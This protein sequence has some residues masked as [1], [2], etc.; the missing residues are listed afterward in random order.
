VRVALALALVFACKGKD[1]EQPTP[2]PSGSA[3]ATDAAPAV[4]W[5]IACE[6][7]LRGAAKLPPVRRVQ[8]VIDGCQPCGEWKPLLLWNTMPPDG[9]TRDQIEQSMLACKGFCDANGKQRFLNNLDD[10]RGKP[11][12]L[13]WRLLGEI[14]K[15]AVSAEPD[16]RY[17]T[18]PLFA[19]DRIGRAAAD[20]PKLAALLDTLELPLPPVSRSGAGYDL[21]PS[22]ATTPNAGPAQITVTLDEIRVGALARAKLG[23]SG[24]QLVQPGESYPGA[25]VKKPA[26]IA[27]ALAALK[28]EGPV[29][30]FAPSGMKATRIAEVLHDAHVPD[31]RLAVSANGAPPGWI[32]AGTVPISLVGMFVHDKP[33]ALSTTIKL[34]DDVDAA[35]KDVKAKGASLGEVT[36]AVTD[37]ATVAGIAKVLGALAYFDVKAAAI[38]TATK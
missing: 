21:A 34:T 2:A 23:K 22:P 36:I 7:A 37:A 15:G 13:P 17:A 16:A 35:V 11:G 28:L 4:D 29:A 1:R 38:T 8:F 5:T 18:A 25:A 3:V 12:R 14:C 30:L 19:L 26:D 9:P 24:V 33:P 32:L 6:A 31:L 27:A 10:A 20:V